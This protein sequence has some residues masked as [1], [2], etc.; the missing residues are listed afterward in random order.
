MATQT[1][2]RVTA[3]YSR[4]NIP[5]AGYHTEIWR[6]PAGDANDT[7]T[8]TPA[9]GRFIVSVLGGSFAHNLSSAGTSTSLT[10]T[11]LATFAAGAQDVV[12][13]IQP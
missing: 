9:T 12:L 4:Q 11:Y 8:I 10:L 3:G 2:T 13:L 7:A 5:F 6:L 1:A